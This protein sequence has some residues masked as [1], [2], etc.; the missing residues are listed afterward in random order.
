M[1]IYLLNAASGCAL[2]SFQM[3][4]QQCWRPAQ[5]ARQKIRDKSHVKKKK[6]KKKKGGGG[7]GGGEG[8]KKRKKTH[9]HQ[10]FNASIQ[11]TSA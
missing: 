6:K 11:E 5:V 4:Y 2:K 1:S 7:K 10:N 8:G 9:G 3:E